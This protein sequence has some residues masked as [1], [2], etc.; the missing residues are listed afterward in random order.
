MVRPPLS[1]GRELFWLC[2][3]GLKPV[4]SPQSRLISCWF[5]SSTSSTV[6]HAPRRVRAEARLCNDRRL[7]VA[8]GAYRSL[9]THAT[10]HI[11]APA[12]LETP[13]PAPEDEPTQED[14]DS[15]MDVAGTL[16]LRCSSNTLI[17][18]AWC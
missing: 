8:L 14:L 17:V 3:T 12:K 15:L 18:A 7:A 11:S 2:S 9:G 16:R 1:I 5:G 13:L 10:G 4:S 6:L